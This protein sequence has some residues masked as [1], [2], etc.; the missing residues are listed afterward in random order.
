MTIHS[1]VCEVKVED[2]WEKRT[3]D[4]VLRNDSSPH[5]RCPECHGQVGA[6]RL[7][8]NGMPAHFEHRLAHKGCRLSVASDGTVWPHPNALT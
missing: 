5:K 7:S 2:Q 6:H 1:K 4:E 3:I 8:N